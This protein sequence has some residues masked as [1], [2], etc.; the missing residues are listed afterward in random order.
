M[1][2]KTNQIESANIRYNLETGESVQDN[3]DT[4][5]HQAWSGNNKL[6]A[7]MSI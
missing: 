5:E 3:G 6:K 1:N 4:S 2:Q 7:Y